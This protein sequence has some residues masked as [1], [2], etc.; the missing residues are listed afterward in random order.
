[1]TTGP[2]KVGFGK[3]VFEVHDT[4]PQGRFCGVKIAFLE[5][6]WRFPARAFLWSQKRVFEVKMALPQ[7][8]FVEK[9]TRFGSPEGSS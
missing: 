5:A 4:F 2:S 1:M 9:E 8:V 7:G 6:K 3:C